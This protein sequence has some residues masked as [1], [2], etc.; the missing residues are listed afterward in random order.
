MSAPEIR[1]PEFKEPWRP[2]VAG[3]AF[4]HSRAR[5]KAGLPIYSVTLDRGMVPRDSLDRHMESDAADGQNLRAQPGDVVYNMMRMWQGAVG[6]APEECMVSPAYVVLRPNKETNPQFFNYWFQT[7]RMLHKLRSY[8]HGLTMD[9]LRLYP[10]DF[11]KI[12]LHLPSRAEQ[13]RIAAFFE[14]IDAKLAALREKADGLRQFKAGLMQRLFSLQLRFTREDGSDFPEWEEKRLVDITAVNPPNEVFPDVFW[15][16]DLESV[17]AG[18][19]SDPK[20][21]ERI[22]APS[23]AQ[24]VLKAGDVLF[25]LVRPYQKNNLLF[26]ED[27]DYVA[28][29]G[30]AQLR[31][32]NS[33]SFVFHLLHTEKFVRDVL[34]RCTGTGYPAITP[35]EL[36]KITVAVPCPDE[37]E[38]IASALDALDAKIDAVVDQIAHMETFKKGLL[39]KMFV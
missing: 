1:F 32:R 6:V 10:D 16:V 11:A 23:R 21:M 36:G 13:D 12:P 18:R 14:D 15:Y 37:Q 20:R 31:A 35:V 26:Q 5:G 30:Y 2:T 25:Q 38:R 22:N 27:G 9:R 7:S 34:E 28:S 3:A 19:L 17:N 39:Q 29:T 4:K 33:N 8:S 24:R